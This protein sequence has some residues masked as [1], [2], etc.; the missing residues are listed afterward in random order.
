MP[1]LLPPVPWALGVELRALTLV[2]EASLTF[3]SCSSCALE[4]GFCLLLSDCH[5]DACLLRPQ[6]W[7]AAE[8][9]VCLALTA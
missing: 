5:A 6:H 3:I 9:E 8:L 1:A 7:S 2:E 4:E